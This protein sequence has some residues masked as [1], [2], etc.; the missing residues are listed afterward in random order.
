MEAVGSLGNAGVGGTSDRGF[1]RRKRGADPRV[2]G[3]GCRA[4][5][6]RQKVPGRGSGGVFEA[7]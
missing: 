1:F 3:V 7:A 4:R 5:R 2:V 6:E